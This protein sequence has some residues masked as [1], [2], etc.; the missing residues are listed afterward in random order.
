MFFVFCWSTPLGR[1]SRD[2]VVGWCLVF[3]ASKIYWFPLARGLHPGVYSIYSISMGEKE[4][5]LRLYIILTQ[6]DE[7]AGTSSTI[8]SGLAPSIAQADIVSQNSSSNSELVDDVFF[9][10]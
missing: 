10:F 6:I 3:K 1:V 7:S 8:E 4:V 2:F 5:N 9:A